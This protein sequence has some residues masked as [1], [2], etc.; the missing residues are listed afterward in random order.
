MTLN[1]EAFL[2]AFVTI[3]L[4][5]IL[6]VLWVVDRF[7]KDIIDRMTPDRGTMVKTVMTP[8]GPVTKKA[9]R[10]M[11]DATAAAI[12]KIQRQRNEGAYRT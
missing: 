10:I 11:D 6:V 8:S 5:V 2:L 3:A 4:P 1:L 7:R 9:P 12:E